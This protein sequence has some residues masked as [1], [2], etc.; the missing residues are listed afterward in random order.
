MHTSGLRH[1][2][3]K[4]YE[5]SRNLTSSTILILPEHFAA[6]LG[7]DPRLEPKLDKPSYLKPGSALIVPSNTMTNK[8][9]FRPWR[10][11]N[12]FVKMCDLDPNKEDDIRKAQTWKRM[13][14][15]TGG[16]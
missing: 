12:G 7:M 14:D 8:R 2:S 11:F 4:S 6:N 10:G 15:F 1:L 9:Y 5:V 16:R 13:M 3:S